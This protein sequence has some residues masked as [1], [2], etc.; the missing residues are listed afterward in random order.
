MP[1]SAST[2]PACG[3][4]SASS[5]GM[6]PGLLIGLHSETGK[7]VSFK[8]RNTAKT[9]SWFLIER[10]GIQ[11]RN[12]SG[13]RRP[14]TGPEGSRAGRSLGKAVSCLHNE[15]ARRTLHEGAPGRPHAS[16]WEPG[17]SRLT[18]PRA[19]RRE[20]RLCRAEC[21]PATLLFISCYVYFKK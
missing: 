15:G 19:E 10:V 13:T 1:G 17:G 8:L 20:R 16:S 6:W 9:L 2:G 4:E 5:S 18:P 7:P 3:A 21:W 11:I 14:L 12:Q